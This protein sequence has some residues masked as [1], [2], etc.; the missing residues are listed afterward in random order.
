MCSWG[1]IPQMS[2][3][4]AHVFSGLDRRLPDVKKDDF[5]ALGGFDEAYWNGCEDVDLCFR[6]QQTGKKIVY[7]PES[8]V[9]HH[10]SKSGQERRWLSPEITP[11]FAPDG[12]R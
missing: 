9:I 6:L 5:N 8:V 2:G 4:S 1:R 7:Q 3:G 12:N 11:G 10:E